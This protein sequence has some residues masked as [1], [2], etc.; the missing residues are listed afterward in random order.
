MET[1]YKVY[2][3]TDSNGCIIRVESTC[4]FD[5]TQLLE[6]G[7]V[8]ID[9]GSGDAYAH[10]QGNYFP[11]KYSKGLYDEEFQSNFK[12]SDGKI[13][14]LTNEEKYD[15]FGK[16]RELEEEKQRQNNTMKSMMERQA[17]VAFLSDF[18]DEEAIKIPYCYDS[19]TSY[20][21]KLLA[22]G[23]RIEYEGK[24]WKV[25]QDIPTV[26]ENQPPSIE[27]ASLYEVIDV[28]HAGTIDDPIPYDQTMTVYKDKYYIEDGITYK[29]IRDSEQPLYATCASLVGNYFE[30]AE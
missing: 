24:L 25:R 10:A 15:L 21:G 16:A 6:D 20:I 14:E 4:F 26:L 23:D 29:C 2:A 13:A 30:L 5:E 12:L 17:Q 18:P 9:E 7:F 28:E 11:I 3:K 27:T 19:W 22:E 8:L 1:T